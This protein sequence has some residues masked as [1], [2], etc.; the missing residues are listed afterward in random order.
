[1]KPTSSDFKLMEAGITLPLISNENSFD[2]LD[3]ST[4]KTVSG[5]LSVRMYVQSISSRV[6]APGNIDVDFAKR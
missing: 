5:E 4:K 2:A 3:G 6:N 1:M